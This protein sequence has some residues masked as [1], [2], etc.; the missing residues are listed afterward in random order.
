[1]AIFDNIIRRDSNNHPRNSDCNDGVVDDV[2]TDGTPS[3][4]PGSN[5]DGPIHSYHT[6]I[7]SFT[8]VS[9]MI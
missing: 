3:P 9:D 5:A 8:C 1:V 6:P 2:D 4:G 7:Y